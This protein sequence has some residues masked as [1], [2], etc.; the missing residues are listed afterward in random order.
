[1]KVL[2]RKGVA[3]HPGP[4]SWGIHRKVF[5][6]ALTGECVGAV[7]N[8][9]KHVNCG[10]RPTCWRREGNTDTSSLREDVKA[11]TGSKTCARTEALC[12]G[13]GRSRHRPGGWLQVRMRNPKGVIS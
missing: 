7:W 1:M 6:Q 9:E 8:P 13:I 10:G 12:T 4:E 3:H 5:T 2:Y 11:P